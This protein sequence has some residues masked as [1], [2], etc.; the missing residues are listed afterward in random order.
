E[1]KEKLEAKKESSKGLIEALEE[2]LKG[3]VDSVNLSTRLVSHPVSLVS[4][5][6]LSLEMERILKQMPDA[7]EI[8]KAK[9]IL[10]I[11]PDHELLGALETIYEKAP[12][13]LG[14]YA[15]LLYDQACLIEGLELE[16]PVGFS[17]NMARLMVE[18]SKL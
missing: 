8:P 1:Q 5:E 9:R 10:E 16:D 3:K 6:G 17:Q 14:T 2:A 4:D 11:N 15:G 13:K 18:V 12:E 7:Q